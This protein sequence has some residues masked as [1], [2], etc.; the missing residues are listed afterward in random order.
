MSVSTVFVT[1]KATSTRRRVIEK[2][3]HTSGLEL[4]ANLTH[5]VATAASPTTLD[6]DTNNSSAR[7][8]VGGTSAAIHKDLFVFLSGSSFFYFLLSLFVDLIVTIPAM[9]NL[10]STFYQW[11]CTLLRP[12]AANL[13]KKK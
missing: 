4:A 8:T 5:I 3:Q 6:T 7:L 10:W 1:A 13:E 11:F 2:K 12:A 9:E